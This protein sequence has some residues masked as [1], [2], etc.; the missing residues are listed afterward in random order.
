MQQERLRVLGQMASGIAHDINNA[1][2]PIMLYTDALLEREPGLSPHARQNLQTIQ[3]AVSDVAETVARMREFYRQRET[4]TEL[5]PVQLNMLILQ[6]R[7]LTRARWEAMPQQRGIVIDLQL[8]LSQDLPAALGIENEIREALINLIFNAVDAM[9]DGGALVIRTRTDESG[10]ICVEVA[11]SGTGMDEETRRRCLEPFFT[12]KGDQGTGLGLAMVYGVM[13]RH[14]GEIAIDS[15]PGKGTTVRLTFTKAESTAMGTAE[16]E[17][18]ALTELSLLLVD[19][20][21]ILLRSLRE[22]LELDRHRVVVAD[23]GQG[24]I[25]TFRASLQ[26]GGTPFAAVIT[27]LGMPHVDGREVAATIKQLSPTT[28][29]I[30]L[31]GWGERLLSAGHTVPHVDRVLSKPPRLRDLRKALAELATARG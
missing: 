15:A 17:L 21:P 18:E 8:E 30:L 10:G 28:P 31:T 16:P 9:P 20:D 27:D 11:D 23:S 14:G 19:D 13:Q 6:L 25:N 29:V 4:Q 12:T 24:G 26:P 22:I 1:I 2:S 7:D 5:R 3:Q